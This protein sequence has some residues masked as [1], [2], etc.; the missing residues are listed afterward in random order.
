MATDPNWSVANQLAD[1]G[2][3]MKYKLSTLLLAVF[4]LTYGIF[5]F[6]PFIPVEGKAYILGGLAIAA[7][8]CILID[9]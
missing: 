8:I 1:L 5:T 6:I 2:A 4:L 9:K 7:G 3:S